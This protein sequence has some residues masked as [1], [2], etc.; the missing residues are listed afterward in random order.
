MLHRGRDF[1]RGGAE[2]GLGGWAKCDGLFG[3][4][5]GFTVEVFDSSDD[6][7]DCWGLAG[8][9]GEVSIDV[10]GAQVGEVG[11]DSAGLH[12][13]RERGDPGHDRQLGMLGGWSRL[14]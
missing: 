6:T 7:L 2:G 11:L 9:E 13:A 8:F 12:S 3:L 1:W 4:T 10:E 14:S 5:I